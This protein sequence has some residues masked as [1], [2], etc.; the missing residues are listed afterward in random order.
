VVRFV[1]GDLLTGR[2]I[3]TVPAILGKWSSV[4]NRGGDVSCTVPLTDPAT[5]RLGLAQS[6]LPGKAFLAA[7]EGDVVL[8]AGPIWKHTYQNDTERLTI[9]A[10]GLWTYFDHRVILPYTDT[11]PTDPA[12]DTRFSDVVTDPDDPGY[13]WPDDTRKS[14]Q[15]IIRAYIEQAAS[16]ASGDVPVI[17]PAEIPGDRERW[18]KGANLAFVGERIAALTAVLGGPDVRFAPRLTSDKL[19][20]EWPV[21]IGTPT[22]PQLFSAQDVIFKVGI[23]G[24]S[25]SGLEY[26]VDATSLGSNAYAS[27]GRGTDTTIISVASDPTLIDA[28]FPLLDIVDSSH[29]TVSEQDTM[30]RYASE[31]AQRGKTPI[32]AMSFYHDVSQRPLIGS[33]NVGDFASVSIRDNAYIAKGRYRMRITSLS[34][35]EQGKRVF[36]ELQPEVR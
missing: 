12:T 8:Q 30:D 3:Q 20:V 13:P 17:L 11:N 15:G 1:V 5:R 25:V 31:A 6:A 29:G 7:V 27:G 4:L 28:G 18:E 23:A 33:F 16:W 19:G 34:G 14:Y 26:S 35:D 22:E 21:L 10:G 2:R 24:S 36:V 9:D 32:A